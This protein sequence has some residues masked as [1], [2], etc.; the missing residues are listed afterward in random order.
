M[1][2]AIVDDNP[3]NI[4]VIEK[5]LKSAGYSSFWKESSAIDLLKRLNGHAE[6]GKIPVDLIL[7]D[8]MMPEMDGIEAC[9]IIQGDERM[10]D[11][12]VII[13]TALGDSNKLAE[14]L[15]AGAIDYVM[16]PVNKV[17]LIA[18]IRV[19]LRLKFEKDWHKENE[20][21]I[22]SEL[23]LARQVQ[24]S[25]LSLPLVQ[26][27]LSIGAA[28]YPSS[29]LAGDFYA[30]YRI[31]E[32]RYGA[33]ILDIM[34]HGISSSLVCMFISSV[35]QD[36]ITRFVSPE[37]VI[38][39]LNRYMNQLNQKSE[40]VSYYFTA[41]YLLIDTHKRTIEYVNAGHPPGFLFEEGKE[42][43]ALDQ[44]SCAVGFFDQM[45]IVKCVYAYEQPIRI[46]LYT[47]GLLEELPLPPDYPD[48][49]SEADVLRDCLHAHVIEGQCPEH[50]VQQVLPAD[51]LEARKDDICLVLVTAF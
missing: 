15:D 45:D 24:G 22:N 21:R 25:V 37:F 39:E 28:Y 5:I 23:E 13:V 4:I 40:S 11:I 49:S 10:K 35:M 51:I 14:A 32:H 12:P 20:A 1:N 38:T 47:D 50:L 2:I 18:R 48:E 19:A 30:W 42:P 34:G 26:E 33:I 29:E 27:N 43:V 16:K 36:T 8:M 6:E 17:E 44:G 41:I 3:V 7:M 46:V 9:R 31:D